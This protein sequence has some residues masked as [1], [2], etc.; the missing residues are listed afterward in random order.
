MCLCQICGKALRGE[1]TDICQNCE[2]NQERQEQE[3]FDEIVIDSD[4]LDMEDEEEDWTD[5]EERLDHLFVE[6]DERE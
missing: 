3:D 1:E 5:L 4:D 2:V 6:D